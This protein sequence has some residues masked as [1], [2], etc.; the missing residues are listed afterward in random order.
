MP[1]SGGGRLGQ[2]GRAEDGEGGERKI[3]FIFHVPFPS[4]HPSIMAARWDDCTAGKN[5][6]NRGSLNSLSP[7]KSPFPFNAISPAEGEEGAVFVVKFE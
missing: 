7:A 4:Q 6:V 2:S 1:Q 3:R 5:K